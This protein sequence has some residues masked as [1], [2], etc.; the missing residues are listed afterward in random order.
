MSLDPL[1]TELQ[2][3]AEKALQ[4]KTVEEG[5]YHLSS[6]FSLFK[7]A[8][9]NLQEKL[10]S[11]NQELNT[12]VQEL[13]RISLFLKNILENISEAILFIDLEGNLLTMNK[14]AREALGFKDDGFVAKKFSSLF[15]NDFFGFSMRE[16]LAFATSY[17][18]I[19]KEI[20]G[21]EFEISTSFV[22]EGPKAYQGMVLILR[23]CTE[24]QR[25]QRAANQRDRLKELGE[26]AATVAHEIRNPLGAIRGYASL[27]HRD[28]EPVSSMREMAEAILEGTKSLET[29]VSTV[30]HYTRPIRLQTE[31]V[32]LGVFLRQLGKFFKM[33]PALTQEVNFVTHIPDAPILAPIDPA[34]LKSAL[35]NLLFNGLQAMTPGGGILTLS[36]LKQEKTCQISVCDTGV[37][38]NEEMQKN[39]FSLFFTTKKKGT[40]LG[41]VE[42]QKIV[43]AH[44]GTI[45][46]R[47]TPKKGTTFTITLPLRRV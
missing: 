37:G 25:L 26:M 9:A 33:D 3:S 7:T 14:A 35:L 19:Y 39:L 30:L 4:S 28:L 21:K 13:N 23:D 24:K 34:A 11:V 31:S 27:L 10:E 43:H 22:L 36:L 45:D 29:L 41:L 16:A 17:R 47:S 40:G 38:M 12:K 18:L 2:Q 32:D 6:A 46:V 8:S 42:V 15:S 20:Q 5:I 1:F 44:Q